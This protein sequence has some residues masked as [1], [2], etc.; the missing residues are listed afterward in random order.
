MATI[1]IHYFTGTGNTAHSVKL[2]SERLREKGNE[3]KIIQVQKGV[4][5]PV[6]APDFHLIAFPVLSWAAPVLMKKYV[7]EMPKSG[8]AKTAILAVNGAII[9]NR[10]LVKGYTGQALEQLENILRKKKY[11]VFLTGN[12]SFPDNWTQFTNPCKPDEV[13][14]IFMVGDAEVQTFSE[15]FLSGKNELYRCGIGNIIWSNM[16]ANLFGYLGRRALGKFY[17]ADQNCTNCGICVKS[18]PVSAINSGKEKPWWGTTCEDCNQC[19]NICPEK[20]IQVSLSL[21]IIQCVLNFGLTIWAIVAILKYI[22]LMIPLDKLFLIPIE[23]VLIFLA[24]IFFIWVL[25]VPFD[26]FFRLLMKI[27]S[28]RIFFSK[29]YTT[30]FRRYV[31]PGF[32]P[33]GRLQ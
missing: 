20:A 13:K 18:C 33:L 6:E 19:I 1:F 21:F 2:I 28:I 15:K 7:S 30:N 3:V 23:I 10:N 27:P 22:P 12:A 14:Q 31:A 24:T 17:I 32:K 5:P 9:Y 16:V 29:S 25:M 8:R 26:A 11:D 4:V